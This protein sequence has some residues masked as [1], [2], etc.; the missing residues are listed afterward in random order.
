MLDNFKEL[1]HIGHPK[2]FSE[3]QVYISH[4]VIKNENFL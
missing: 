3:I 4:E 2:L 1:K